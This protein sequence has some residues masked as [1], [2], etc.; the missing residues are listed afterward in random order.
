MKISTTRFVILFLVFAFAF[1]FM[2]NSILGP[3]VRL[4]PVNGE[5][6]P[7]IGS[8]IAWKSTAATIMLPIK[9]V[10][11][12]PLSGLFK[13]PDPPPPLLALAF[14]I[15]WTAIALVIHFLL[16]KISI[17]KKL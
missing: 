8:T 12:G 14:A 15:Y 9:M 7:G 16:T 2:S 6:F 5:A 3:E 4:F 10:L 1:Q 17:S 13:L 11:L